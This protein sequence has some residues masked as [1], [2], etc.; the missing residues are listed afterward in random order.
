MFEGVDDLELLLNDAFEGL[1]AQ[2]VDLLQF[3]LFLGQERFD[4]LLLIILMLFNCR[5]AS[6]VIISICVI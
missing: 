4:V 1:D 3:L 6:G 5:V 2:L